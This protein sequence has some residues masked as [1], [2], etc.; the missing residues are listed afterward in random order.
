MGKK[1]GKL[2]RKRIKMM[3]NEAEKQVRKMKIR[4][5]TDKK[6]KKNQAEKRGKR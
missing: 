4:Q 6:D 1:R 5:K 2:G 3:K